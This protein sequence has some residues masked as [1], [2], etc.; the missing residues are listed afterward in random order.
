M[1]I[2][3]DIL[4]AIQEFEHRVAIGE[5][6]I[7][8]ELDASHR[9]TKPYVTSASSLGHCP[10][11][12]AF[13]EDST[14][15]THEQDEHTMEHYFAQGKVVGAMIAQAMEESPLF[16][17]VVRELFVDVDLPTP[18]TGHVDIVAYSLTHKKFIIVEVKFTESD[19]M[20][21]AYAMQ[22]FA[23]LKATNASNAFVVI[24]TRRSNTVYEIQEHNHAISAARLTEDDVL[25]ADVITIHE[26]Y[27]E[28]DRQADYAQRGPDGAGFIYNQ[29][30]PIQGGNPVDWQCVSVVGKAHRYKKGSADGV[31]QAGDLKPGVGVVRCP[32]A[33]HCYPVLMDIDTFKFDD[34]DIIIEEVF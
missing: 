17:G 26:F 9:I 2:S 31:Y 12:R 29:T 30:T 8:I 1:S 16:S 14:T 22:T 33:G 11:K 13:E 6:L 20:K 10:L 24:V 15:P 3:Q 34:K 18:Y 21:P 25:N 23:Y 28:L 4:T 5:S 27:V 7:Q 19:A 32:F